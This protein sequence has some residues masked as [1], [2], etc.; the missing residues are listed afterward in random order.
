MT[1]DLGLVIGLLVESLHSKMSARA[2]T[3]SLILARLKT[4][5][6]IDA[7]YPPLRTNFDVGVGVLFL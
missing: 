3:S 4:S 2:F 5:T 7:R 6:K 1:T